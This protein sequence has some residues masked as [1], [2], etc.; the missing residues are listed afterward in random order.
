VSAAV[1]IPSWP[2][3]PEHRD[4]I[5]TLLVMAATEDRWGDRHR[6]VDLLDNVEQIVGT[7]PQSYEQLRG[8]CLEG[9]GSGAFRPPLD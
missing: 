9:T 5:D 6:A 7:L 8:R 4:A 2:S 3:D 1:R